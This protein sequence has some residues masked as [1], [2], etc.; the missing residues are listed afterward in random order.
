MVFGIILER[1]I[2]EY[3]GTSLQSFVVWHC[4]MNG[5]VPESLLVP[6]AVRV[7]RVAERFCTGLNKRESICG[8][9]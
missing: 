3:G 5:F 7:P 9:T 4:V 1:I 8:N 2:R 6:T